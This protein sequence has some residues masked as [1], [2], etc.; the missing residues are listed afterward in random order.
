MNI[1]IETIIFIFLISFKLI[2]KNNKYI[3]SLKKEVKDQIE[4]INNLKIKNNE[5]VLFTEKVDKSIQTD[6]SSNS[7][8]GLLSPLESLESLKNWDNLELN[9]LELNI[10]SVAT[11]EL[12][13]SP[14]ENNISL[15]L[16]NFPDSNLLDESNLFDTINSFLILT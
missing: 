6:L 8:D 10:E 7:I 3:K 2:E 13:I 4:E 16:P 15:S 14:I 5:G 1:T 12:N 11:T 9:S